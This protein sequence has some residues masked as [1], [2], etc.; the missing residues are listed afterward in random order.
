MKVLR[1]F[2]F[3]VA[4]AVAIP[5]T[6]QTVPEPVGEAGNYQIMKAES[7]QVC[8][9][10]R[11]LSSSAGKLMVY[12]TY[13]TK[14]G[15][16][17]N[18][19]GYARETELADGMITITVSIDGTETVSRET[20]TSGADFLFPFETMEEV[21]AHEALVATG[22]VMSIAIG[23]MDTVVVALDDHRLA[24]DAMATCLADM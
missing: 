22:E 21:E 24:L 11:E 15:Q 2:L 1:P 16:R 12:S 4:L 17:W 9:A 3:S 10:T 8:F 5:A 7:Q 20:Q 18:V 14:P 19:A 6:A 13:A 23:E